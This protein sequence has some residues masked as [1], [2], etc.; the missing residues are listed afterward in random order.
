MKIAQ[1]DSAGSTIILEE[2]VAKHANGVAQISEWVEVE[3]TPRV[4][5]SSEKLA[6]LDSQVKSTQ[7]WLE[8]LQR[9]RAELL[10]SDDESESD[11]PPDDDGECFRGGE[12]AAYL[13]EQQDRI[14]RTL[15]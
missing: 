11:E 15:K 7:K 3:F 2:G 4:P 1:F 12:A 6:A 8:S 5:S 13:A 14:Q 10:I 9:Q